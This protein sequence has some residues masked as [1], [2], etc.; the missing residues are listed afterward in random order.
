MVID[1]N[2]NPIP[3]ATV[4]VRMVND[5]TTLFGAITGVDGRFAIDSITHKCCD[6]RVS[7]V[8]FIPFLKRIDL[9]LDR[10]MF[11]IK[12]DVDTLQLESVTVTRNGVG[13]HTLVDR[14]LF[15]PDAR[16]AN[17]SSTSFDLL[18]KVP[19]VS[20]R[21][22]DM[23]IRV[24]GSA[25]VLVLVNGSSSNRNIGAI[26]PKDIDRVELIKNPG[27]EFGGET[28]SVINIV[29]KIQPAY[30]LSV[31]A[32]AEYSFFN[33]VNNSGFQLGYAFKNVKLF[34]GYQFGFLEEKDIQVCSRRLDWGAGEYI[35]LESVSID[36]Q[37]TSEKHQLQCGVDVLLGQKALLSIT[38]NYKPISFY[39]SAS[40]NN[41]LSNGADVIN[42]QTKNRAEYDAVQQNYNLYLKK[43]FGKPNHELEL[44]SDFLWFSRDRENFYSNSQLEDA[45]GG[46]IQ[47]RRENTKIDFST[48]TVK[49]AYF[50]PISDKW[51]L[52]GGAQYYWR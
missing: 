52:R 36:G 46:F 22:K 31:S 50:R 37:Y 19:G 40:D 26:N 51:Q 21:A 42:Y 5:S 10:E 39:E 12:L 13:L 43:E 32:N 8:G 6:V 7:Y 33:P 4:S 15:V 20:I 1:S 30:G 27:A 41:F 48:V 45:Y 35:G 29:L 16:I 14:T 11:D 9:S 18:S 44:N 34:A 17:F 23:Q 49:L 3:Y 47:P 2:R 38:A 28:N 25:N 24:A